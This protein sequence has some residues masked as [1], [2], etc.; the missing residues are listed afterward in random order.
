MD[1]GF[2]K[3]ILS[4]KNYNDELNTIT[5]TPGTIHQSMYNIGDEHLNPKGNLFLSKILEREVFKD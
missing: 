1:E 2:K 4:S 5:E 3:L